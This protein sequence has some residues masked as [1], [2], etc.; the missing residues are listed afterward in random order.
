MPAPSL[1]TGADQ[2]APTLPQVGAYVLSRTLTDAGGDT[3]T[4]TFSDDT[5]PTADRVTLLIVDACRWVLLATGT[6]DPALT[7]EAQS[8]AALRTAGMVELTYPRNSEDVTTGQALLE[9]ARLARADLVT[10]NRGATG[11]DP[12]TP[13]GGPLLPV[14]AFPPPV[15][16]GDVNHF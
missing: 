5:E 8:V 16:W 15:A 10:A 13:A 11:V 14:Y 7:D 1:P 2:W 6:L 12:T 9:Q 4:G 3:P